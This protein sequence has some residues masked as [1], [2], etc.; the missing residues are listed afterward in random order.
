MYII[1]ILNVEIMSANYEKIPYSRIVKDKLHK[2][3][4]I[5]PTEG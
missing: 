1:G 3:F 5:P 2:I 4:F